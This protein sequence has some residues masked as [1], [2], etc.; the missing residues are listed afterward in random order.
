MLATFFEWKIRPGME[1]RFRRGWDTITRLLHGEGSFGSALFTNHAGH[2][3]AFAMW[4]D[5]ETR[6]RA[7]APFLENP[8]VHHLEL[9]EAIEREIQRMDL[10][11]ENDL[12]RLGRPQEK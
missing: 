6:D 9:R 2:F 4:P 11:C 7:F 10:D 1:D 5:R 12:W 8:T 3:C